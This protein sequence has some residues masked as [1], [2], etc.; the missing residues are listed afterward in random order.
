MSAGH[1]LDLDGSSTALPRLNGELVFDE[2][3]QMRAFGVAAEL[4]EA[5]SFSWDEFRTELISAIASWEASEPA[6]RRLWAYYEHWLT[7]L[8]HLVTTHGLVGAAVLSA[9]TEAYAVRPHGHD[10]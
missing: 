9:R 2:P 6:G 7:A 10:H 5:G 4:V 8:E 3:W 1:V